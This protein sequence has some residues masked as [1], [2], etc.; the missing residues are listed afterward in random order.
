MAEPR[1]LPLPLPDTLADDAVATAPLRWWSVHLLD[2]DDHSYEYVI[3]MLGDL[4]GYAPEKAFGLARLVDNHGRVIVKTAG[5]DDCLEAQA[6]IHGYGADPRIGR[7]RGS[8][9]A[10]IEPLA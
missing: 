8:M 9:S 5:H 1:T 2:D 3:D 10:V 6:K 4:F 7:C